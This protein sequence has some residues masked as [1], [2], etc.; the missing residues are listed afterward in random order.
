LKTG[1]QLAIPKTFSRMVELSD[2]HFNL[3]LW[4]EFSGDRIEVRKLCVDAGSGEIASR[5]LLQLGLPAIVKE[6]AFEVI[7][8]AAFWTYEGQEMDLDWGNLNVHHEFL[9]QM[10]WREHVSWGNPRQEI[11]QYFGMKRTA[12]NALIRKIAR[13]IPLPGSHEQKRTT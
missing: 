3:Q 9:A 12:A 10:Y 11:M 6:I 8:D 13:G 5:K 7:P 2:P 4:C 1:K